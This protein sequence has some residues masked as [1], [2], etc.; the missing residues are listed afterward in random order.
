MPPLPAALRRG[1]PRG[2]RLAARAAGGGGGLW[3]RLTADTRDDLLPPSDPAR[4][5]LVIDFAGFESES[6]GLDCA[7]RFVAEA[8]RLGW[9]NLVGFGCL[10]GPRYLGT[11]LAGRRRRRR[12]Q[13]VVIE[14]FGRESG[15][16]LGALLEG[17]EIWLYGQAQCHV[18]M[19]ADS[20]Y[21]FVL[22]DGLNTCLYAAHGGTLSLWDSGSRFAVAGQNKVLLADGAD[23][24]AGP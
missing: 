4:D 1:G 2:G 20:G 6:F 16:F 19:K 18:G 13:G 10:G 11:N 21:L 12:P 23:A 24:G 15:D 7:S 5:V 9:R 17:A 22:Q 14:L 8:V 3:A